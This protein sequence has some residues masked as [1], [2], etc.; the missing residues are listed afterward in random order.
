MGF[1]AI[2]A[3]PW[4]SVLTSGRSGAQVWAPDRPDVKIENHG[5]GRM[6]PNPIILRYHFDNFVR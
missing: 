1:S 3:N 5:L 2:L 4:F 6:A